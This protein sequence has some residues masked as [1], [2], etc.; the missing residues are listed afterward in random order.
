MADKIKNHKAKN[1][2]VRA[3]IVMQA[4]FDT[5]HKVRSFSKQASYRVHICATDYWQLVTNCT[6]HQFL[7]VS[8]LSALYE[9]RQ[10]FLIIQ[11]FTT[12]SRVTGTL[13]ERKVY[14]VSMYN[15]LFA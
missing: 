1:L 13:N 4:H 14:K 7:S 9:I 11:T 5:S 15:N 8:I 6:C 10:R 3:K 12:L 2:N